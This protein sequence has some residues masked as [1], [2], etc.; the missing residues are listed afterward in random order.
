MVYIPA[1]GVLVLVARQRQEL[2]AS[3]TSEVA[4]RAEA[5]VVPALEVVELAI[6]ALEARIPIPKALQRQ[7]GQSSSE[8]GGMADR[9]HWT[10]LDWVVRAVSWQ[11]ALTVQPMGAR[12]R[13]VLWDTP[14]HMDQE[15]PSSLHILQLRV[16][17]AMERSTS[18]TG[19]MVK[20]LR[21]RLPEM[22]CQGC[23]STTTPSTTSC[24]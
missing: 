5:Q 21:C 15:R 12:R 19:H 6:E 20:A 17:T 1:W 14:L 16:H 2:K 13:L 9:R 18:T 7:V 11:Q 22:R 24:W 3:W 23:T 4:L 10:R 8:A